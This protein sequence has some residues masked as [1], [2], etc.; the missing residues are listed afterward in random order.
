MFI[1]R[2]LAI[3]FR[4]YLNTSAIGK[5]A[6]SFFLFT[7]INSSSD[8]IKESNFIYSLMPDDFN[9]DTHIIVIL[10]LHI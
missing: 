5:K 2:I 4:I 3:L 8:S 6:A 9:S 1:F 7:N 10:N